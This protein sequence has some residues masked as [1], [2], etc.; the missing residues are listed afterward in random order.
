MSDKINTEALSDEEFDKHMEVEVSKPEDT[1]EKD[2][3]DM[4]NAQPA[5]AS[6]TGV[7]DANEEEPTSQEDSDIGEE[8]GDTD[9][10]ENGEDTSEAEID[11]KK[12]YEEATADYKANGKIMP[13]IKEPKDLITALQM[14]SNYAQ[15]TAALKPGLKRVKMLK[16]ISDEQLNE[17]LDFNARNPDV[18]KKA[19]KDAGLDPLDIDIDDEIEYTPTDHSIPDSQIEFEEIVGKIEDTPEFQVTSKVVTEDWDEASRDAMYDDPKLIVGLND[20]IRMGRFE[21]VSALMDQART[22]GKD[23]GLNDLELYQSIVTQLVSE[24]WKPKPMYQNAH[25]EQSESNN[26]ELNAQ[27]QQAG[28]QPRKKAN[29]NKRYDPVTMSDEEFMELFE[30]GAKF[31]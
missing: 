20:E 2:I 29:T 22:L 9:E 18:I 28:I 26:P 14:A 5:E 19:M 24:G 8:P 7:P 10:P 25:R 3:E 23:N 27:R 12:F 6:D 13:G 15:K 30:S 1:K 16:D 4:D 17:M 31:L 11:Y 21:E